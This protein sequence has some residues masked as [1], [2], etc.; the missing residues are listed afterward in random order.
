MAPRA[1]EAI[2]P[3]V[4]IPSEVV[5]GPADPALVS[6][7]ILYYAQAAHKGDVAFEAALPNAERMVAA[8]GPAQSE[9]W[10]AAQQ[11]VSAL[12]ASRAPVTEAISHLDELA[13]SQVIANG[14]ILPGDLEIIQAASRLASTIGDREAAVIDR[15]QR[16]LAR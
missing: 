14:G 7:V 3:R 6:K 12:I 15:L 9:S 4:P 1:A 13:S 16:Q 10:I 8:A 11:A 2:D 5:S